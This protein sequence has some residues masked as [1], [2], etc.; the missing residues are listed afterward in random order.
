MRDACT[1]TGTMDPMDARVSFIFERS[2][3][4][5]SFSE[6]DC[7]EDLADKS[8]G[9]DVFTGKCK[10][11]EGAVGPRCDKC[12]RG[13]LRVPGEGCMSELSPS[14]MNSGESNL[15]MR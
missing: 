4:S 5:S 9:C 15:R 3:R 2:S 1:I 13:Y 14:P 8:Y 10:C 11:K 7:E 12:E 6:C